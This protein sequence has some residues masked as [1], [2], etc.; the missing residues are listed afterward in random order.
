MIILKVLMFIGSGILGLAGA[1]ALYMLVIAVV[2]GF[3]V[4]PQPL[5]GPPQ[6]RG[7]PPRSRREI[8][9]SVKN[10]QVRGWLYLPGPHHKAPHPCI[11]MAHGLGGTRAMGLEG[12]ASRFC[13][14]GFAVLAF[15]YRHFGDSGGE[16]RQLAWI[17]F[18]LEDYAAAIAW[19]RERAAIDP[20][21]IALWGT[22][23]SGAHV[24]V[25]AAR[26]SGIACASAQVPLLDGEAG[27]IEILKR[28]GMGYVLRMTFGHAL[29]DLVRSWLG[30]PPHKIPLVGRSGTIAVMADHGAWE[31][32]Q[33]L[34]P[35]GFINEA[36][37]RILIRMDK[38][39]PLKQLE[40]VSCPLLLQFADKDIANPPELV[41]EARERVGDRGQIIRYP[42]D[43]FDIY[44][45]HDF[46]RAANDQVEFFRKY[47]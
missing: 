20:S 34:A 24:I 4:P 29:R 45:G 25:S 41:E 30:L 22:S 38:Y 16:P 23:M 35:K 17:P 31:A 33:E 28:F 27:G 9:I 47:L 8:S 14:A 26:D 44:L 6:E 42:I 5:P 37:A 15:D 2:P 40:R 46:E 19:A 3:C 1:Y 32:F 12:Y 39:K 18:Q 21:R 11:V 7:E 10:E 36:C 13:D 43:H